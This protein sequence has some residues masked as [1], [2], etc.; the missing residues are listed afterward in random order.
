MRADFALSQVAK[1]EKPE[2]VE[3]YLKRSA[4][5]QL[6]WDAT[7]SVNTTTEFT[8]FLTPRG[9]NG[10]FNQTGYNPG[11]CGACS[12]PSLTYEGTPFEYSFTIPHDM[13]TL[14]DLMGGPEKFE[15][16]LDYIFVPYTSQADLGPN[17]AGIN[18]IMNIG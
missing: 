6:L 10:T 13:E 3:K 8:G 15:K 1:G 2:D 17:G 12:W 7:T 14:L 4:G 5:W 9:R 18:T 11:T 16:R